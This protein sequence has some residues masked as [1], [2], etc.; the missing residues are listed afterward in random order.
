MVTKPTYTLASTVAYSGQLDGGEEGSSERDPDRPTV[1]VHQMSDADT[2]TVFAFLEGASDAG[3]AIDGNLLIVGWNKCASD[4]LGY[5]PEEAIGR[6]CAEILQAV[7]SNGDP[8]CVPG[9]SADCCFR[10]EKPFEARDCMAHRKDGTWAPVSITSVALS[11]KVRQPLHS[12]AIAVIYIHSDTAPDDKH[13]LD[14]TLRIFTFG[15]FGLSVGD[16]DLEV[17]HW[18]R[19]QSVTILK[20]L[21]AHSGRS[22]PREVLIDCLWPEVNE[23]SGRKRLKTCIYSL[24]QHLRNA[25]LSGQ[26]VETTNEAYLL[27]SEAIWV[28]TEVFEKS[29]VEGNARLNEGLYQEALEFYRVAEHLYRGEY[30]D[31]DIHTEWCAEERERFRQIFMEMLINMAECYEQCTDY[32]KTIAVYRKILSYDSCRESTHRALMECLAR[33]GHADSAITQYRYCRHTLSQELD[34]EPMPETEALYR[35]I[36]AGTG[37]ATSNSNGGEEKGTEAQT[38]IFPSAPQTTR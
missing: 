32:P 19:K 31:E 26:I 6:H 13:L 4:L 25:G 34:V 14:K 15:R 21:A 38:P 37:K 10:R 22:V 20:F 28:D 9:C 35:R 1:G 3:F 12:E 17:E 23:L 7:A 36:L 11:K 29:I 33:T 2:D 30:L 16:K 27:R 24:R 5:E 18:D 8:L